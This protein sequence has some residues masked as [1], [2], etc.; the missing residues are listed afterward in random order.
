MWKKFLEVLY[1]IR[2]NRV[3]G[4][5]EFLFGQD[6]YFRKFAPNINISTSKIV[7]FTPEVDFELDT[8]KILENKFKK[9]SY[10]CKDYKKKYKDRPELI[11]V[12]ILIESNCGEK[13]FSDYTKEEVDY[14][15]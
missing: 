5:I 10:A 1:L 6:D 7:E 14:L 13:I 8:L 15:N 3:T 12:T 11:F 9:N 4:L 2:N